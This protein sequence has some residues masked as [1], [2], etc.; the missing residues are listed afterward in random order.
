GETFANPDDTSGRPT[1]EHFGVTKAR[2]S[3]LAQ[4][5]DWFAV[6]GDGSRLVIV[7]EGELRAVPAGEP[8]G[9]AAGGCRHSHPQHLLTG[10]PATR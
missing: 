10:A 1:L 5:L 3:E 9:S 4:H 7:D 2:K 8:G 6:S